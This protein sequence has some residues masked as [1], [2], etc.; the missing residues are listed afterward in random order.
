[1]IRKRNLKASGDAAQEGHGYGSDDALAL[2]VA[3]LIVG[4]MKQKTQ[5][6]RRPRQDDN[7]ESFKV[8]AACCAFKELDAAKARVQTV[9]LGNAA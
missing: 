3:C 1:M 5:G 2:S 9:T 6:G 4:C 7:F 8:V